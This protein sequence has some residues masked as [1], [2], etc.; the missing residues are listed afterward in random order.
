MTCK[1]VITKMI[2]EHQGKRDIFYSENVRKLLSS[3]F[4]DYL[5]HFIIITR[6]QVLLFKS[7]FFRPELSNYCNIQCF[8]TGTWC[9]NNDRDLCSGSD[10]AETFV[11]VCALF[12]AKWLFVGKSAFNNW[13]LTTRKVFVFIDRIYDK[14]KLICALKHTYV[15]VILTSSVLSKRIIQL[16]FRCTPF[17]LIVPPA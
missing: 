9:I 15:A 11:C 16:T 12:V 14:T 7:P 3:S 5:Q 1:A 13:S 17:F 2:T 6:M 4:Q 10:D 8:E